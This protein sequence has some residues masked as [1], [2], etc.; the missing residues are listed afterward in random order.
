MNC[1]KVS[2]KEFFESRKEKENEDVDKEKLIL[3]AIDKVK[4][5]V[6]SN[7][8]RAEKTR[9]IIINARGI[10]YEILLY[11][12]DKLPNS[13]LGKLK[14]AIENNQKEVL[15]ELC[16]DYDLEKKEFYFDKDP[17]IVNSLLNYY[18][19]DRFHTDDTICGNFLFN[20]FKYWQ[21]D[22]YLVHNCCQFKFLTK[23]EEI[24]QDIHK[25]YDI[26]TEFNYKE[27]FG[28]YCLPKVREKIWNI[29]ECPKSSWLALVSFCF[30]L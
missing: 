24:K 27:D 28:K 25:Q 18:S 22:P 9:K 7:L 8:T 5:H 19:E 15:D 14:S 13:R 1:F 30:Y 17:Y 11:K 23:I 6:K 26:I 20:E 12:M 2:P 21:L 29:M 16:D 4:I 10:K 3:N